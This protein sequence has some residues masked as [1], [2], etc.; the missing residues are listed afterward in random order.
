MVKIGFIVE[1]ACEKLVV[2]S[3]QFKD[4][5]QRYGYD[6]QTPVINAQGGGNLLPRHLQSHLQRLQQAGVSQVYVLTDAENETVT[7]VRSRICN[8]QLKFVFISVKALGRV[9]I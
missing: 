9:I 8:V 6:L 7:D 1:G 3:S 2:E 4:F 5:L